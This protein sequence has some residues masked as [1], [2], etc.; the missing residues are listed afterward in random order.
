MRLDHIAYRVA[1]RHKTVQFFREAFSYSIADE[2]QIDFDDGS[3]AQCFALQPPE[4]QRMSG[5]MHCLP[6][7]LYLMVLLIQ[8]WYNG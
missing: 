6:I 1:D 2:F 7:F 4:V 3:K 5:N 8:L